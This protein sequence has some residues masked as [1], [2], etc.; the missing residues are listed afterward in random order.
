MRSLVILVS[1]MAS[2][3]ALAG[4]WDSGSTAG[5]K[6]MPHH[7]HMMSGHSVDANGD[8]V[9]S[10]DEA[11]AFPRLAAEFDSVDSNKDGQLDK[12]EMTAHREARHAQMRAEAEKRWAA[13]DADG[14][15][16]LSQAEAQGSMPYIAENFDK[17]D[18]NS[19]GQV[20]REEMMQHRMHSK[21]EWKREFRDRWTAAD[22]DGDGALDLAEAQTGM[23]RL[24]ENFS[25]FDTNNDG[26][27]TQQEMRAHRRH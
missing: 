27:V 1:V 6:A 5:A 19:D 23:P 9:V 2:G 21:K 26:K 18:S 25:S 20:S 10:R 14:S 24:A 7:G 16:A 4:A 3:A 11:Q 12:A 15:G 13:A 17:L 8:G 22:K